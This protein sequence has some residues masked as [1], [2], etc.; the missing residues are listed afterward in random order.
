MYFAVK[1]YP[2]RLGHALSVWTAF[3][4]NATKSE[5]TII[6]SVLLHTN[7]F[8]GRVASDHIMIHPNSSTGRICRVPLD[9]HRGL[10]LQG[11]MTLN[12][13]I[14]GGHDGTID[15]KILVCVK[16]IGA[17]KRITMKNRTER[18]LAEIF[19]FDHTGE[20]RWTLW[21]GLIESAKEWLPGKTILLISNPG[22][23]ML[24]S[25]KG[26]LRLQR[27][28]LVDVDPDFPDANWLKKYAEDLIKRE[29]LCLEFPEGIWDVEAA[30]YGLY[31]T[32]YTLAEVDEW[33]VDFR[34]LPTSCSTFP[35]CVRIRGSSSLAILMSQSWKYLLCSII[36]APCSCAPS[37]NI[38]SSSLETLFLI[39]F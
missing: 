18:E 14:S 38:H 15:A 33:W 23:Q 34:L 4:S 1:A 12:S 19:I 30:E 11:L 3:I 37:G 39:H 25:G 2:L 6:P 32:L 17:R 28:T 24:P 35:G 29:S 26:C 21:E 10:P 31:R 5:T 36:V 16:S 22:Y 27:S 8:P 13:Y 20:V 9:Y 7:L